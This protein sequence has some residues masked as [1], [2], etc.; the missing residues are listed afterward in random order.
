[1]ILFE[2][3]EDCVRKDGKG[4]SADEIGYHL[5]IVHPFLGWMF[6][7]ELYSYPELARFFKQYLVLYRDKYECLLG[8]C[9]FIKF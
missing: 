2:F 5:D 9:L 7:Y 6:L 1:M 3:S 4:L 8:D